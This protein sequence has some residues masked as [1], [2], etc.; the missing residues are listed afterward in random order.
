MMSNSAATRSFQPFSK[1]SSVGGNSSL[2]YRS[3][4]EIGPSAQLVDK[5]AMRP[6]NKTIRYMSIAPFRRLCRVPPQVTC[7]LHGY[8]PP[9]PMAIFADQQDQPRQRQRPGE[10]GPDRHLGRHI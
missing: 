6:A 7:I 9:P 10:D 2:R 3:M 1:F 5:K 4:G 8:S